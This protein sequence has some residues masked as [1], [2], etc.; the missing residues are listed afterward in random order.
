MSLIKC[1]ECG[2][3]ISSNASV[4]PNCGSHLKKKHKIWKYI[5]ISYFIICILGICITQLLKNS[6]KYDKNRIANKYIDVSIDEGKKIDAILSNCGIT[7][8]ESFKHDDLLDNAH[9]NGE[10]GYRIDVN[11]N[12]DNIILYLNTDKTVYSLSY[13]TYILYSD[14]KTVSMIQ[15]YTLSKNEISDLMIKCEN[16]VKEIL[17]SP[18]TA[19]FPNILEWKFTKEKN[20]TTV[21]GYVDSQNGL[22]A[23]VRS[24]FKFIINTDTDTIVSFIFDGQELITQ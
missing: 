11:D 14:G 21:Q 3:E 18:S 8:V 7:K 22:G 12:I 2:K 9:F 23:E 4:C 15:D 10:T 5:I 24:T 1:K 16:K 20:I 17:K 13:N 6:D 19:N